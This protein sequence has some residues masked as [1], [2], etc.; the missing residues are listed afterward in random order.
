M[1][2][3]VPPM[4]KLAIKFTYE[5]YRLLPEEKRCELIEG[6]FYM[7]PSPSYSHQ[8][9]SK[10]LFLALNDFVNTHSLGQVLYA[11][12]DVVLSDEDVVQPDIL[13]I[14]KERTRIITEENIRGAPD[15]V[16]EIL[17]PGTAERDLTLKRKLYAKFGVREYW[18]VDP[19]HE[20]IEVLS[21][22][23]RGYNKA[24]SYDIEK[25]LQSPLLKGLSLAIKRIF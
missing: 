20:T 19:E 16:V 3:E 22:S 15:L 24:G 7:V 10:A 8:T 14:S 4:S 18:L 21:L 12:L 9:I 11:P 13:F 23:A 17:S 2:T 6:E 5:D 1:I 25:T